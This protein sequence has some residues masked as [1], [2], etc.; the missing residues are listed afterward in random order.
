MPAI[1]AS[2]P[3]KIILFGEHA[4]V[5][6]VP[7]IAVPVNQVQA[8]AMVFA[9]PT[10]PPGEIIIEAPMI[11]LQKTLSELSEDDPL[12]VAIHGVLAALEISRSPACRLRVTSSIPMA[13]GLGSSAA[14]SVAVIR[15]L[16]SF[17]G[18]PLEDSRV[19]DLAYEVE[20]IHHGT[21]SGIDN[22]V[23]TYA[24]PIFYRRDPGEC[25]PALM[26]T[27]QVARPFTVVIADTGIQSS[28]VATVG[29]VRR[30]YQAEPER[31]KRMFNAVGMIVEAAREA[32]ESGYTEALGPLMDENHALLRDMGVSSK[33]LEDLA[34]AARRAGAFGA[35]LSGGGRGGNLIALADGERA[36]KIAEALEE[37]GAKATIITT[38]Q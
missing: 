32:I 21:P 3:G 27:F 20:K 2:A 10:G 26:E 22:S 1:S 28:T 23:I 7:A 8:K 17:L 37:A 30:A 9:N 6:G 15:A 34:Q 25:V 38:V 29:D 24:K 16:S 12:R 33:E 35:K 11:R 31:Y 14:I 19:S 18:N 36:S 5:Y 13:G 4:V